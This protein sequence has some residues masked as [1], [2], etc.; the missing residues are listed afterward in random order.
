MKIIPKTL[1]TEQTARIFAEAAFNQSGCGN[2]YSRDPVEAK[3]SVVR[4]DIKSAF[5]QGF[6]AAYL[7]AKG[8]V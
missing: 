8:E 1:S 6:I 4:G 3:A 2:W 5:V 7:S